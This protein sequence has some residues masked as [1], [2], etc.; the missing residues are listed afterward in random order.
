[1]RETRVFILSICD[2]EIQTAIEIIFR[3]IILVCGENLLHWPAVKWIALMIKAPA[4][5]WM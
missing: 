1:M 5:L 4:M 3:D 2:V